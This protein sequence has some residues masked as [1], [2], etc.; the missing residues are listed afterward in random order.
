MI[1]RIRKFWGEHFLHCEFGASV[2]ITVA[3]C[4][5]FYWLG[6]EDDVDSLLKDNRGPLYGALS[7]IFGS[8]LGF[9][10]TSMSIVI[11]FSGDERLA[12]IRESRHYPMLWRVFMSAIYW[13]AFATVV[14][15][16][17]LVFDRDKSPFMPLFCAVFFVSTTFG[18]RLGRCIWALERLVEIVSKPNQKG[19]A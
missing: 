14:C 1:S 19:K 4:V 15:V 18:F 2:A 9:V 12:L 13:S 6:L 7:A 11:G 17:A 10:I 16:L 3:F 8:L 5:V